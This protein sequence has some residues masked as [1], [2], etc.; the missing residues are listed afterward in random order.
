[1]F[2]HNQ[3]T[4]VIIPNSV[5]EIGP[6]AFDDNPLTRVTIGTNVTIKANNAFPEDFVTVYNNG[7]KVAGTYISRDGGKTWRKS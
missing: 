2:A 3:L 5:T 1:V 7:G 6:C 4:S